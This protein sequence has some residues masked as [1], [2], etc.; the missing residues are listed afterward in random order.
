[1]KP[2][3][4][5]VAHLTALLAAL[6][7]LVTPAT[8]AEELRIGVPATVGPPYLSGPEAGAGVLPSLARQLG[9]ALKVEARLVVLPGLRIEAAASGG[10]I[11]LWCHAHPTWTRAPDQFQWLPTL[12]NVERVLVGAAGQPSPGAL[13]RLP[14]GQLIGT[15]LGTLYPDLTERF[16]SG[17]F[18]RDDALS[19]ERLLK[20]LA[21]ARVP[22][23]VVDRREL[24][25]Q[26]Q[27]DPELRLAPWRLPIEATG[28]RCGLARSSS[29]EW[30]RLTAAFEPLQ[31]ST[32]FEAALRASA[33][34]HLAFVV[35][36]RSK[37]EALSLQELQ[38]LYL[39]SARRLA[40][41]SAV[42]LYVR[43]GATQRQFLA[44]ALKLDAA[45][46]RGTWSRLVFSGRATAPVEVDDI[47]ELK[48]RLAGDPCSLSFVRAADVDP[49]LKVLLLL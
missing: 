31:T 13:D 32:W 9:Q 35:S 44:Q 20:K 19:S 26:L 30:R 47:V 1:M 12:Y 17:R 42:S 5:L 38:D 39:G 41:C 8:G 27:V 34:A 18:K 7:V 33:Q 25:A 36:A 14:E 15:T 11:D 22:Y 3:A 28:A 6:L 45:G 10:D 2:A 4:H 40:G 43:T 21:L 29:V 24:D 16:A 49:S 23:A 48:Q 46:F 37:A